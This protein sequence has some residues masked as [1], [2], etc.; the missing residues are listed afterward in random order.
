MRHRRRRAGFALMLVAVYTT[1][2][3]GAW[4]LAARQV[5]ALV[6]IKGALKA[7][8]TTAILDPDRLRTRAL[9]Y[10]LALLETGSPPV[11]PG[12]DEPYRCN[13]AITPARGRA[14]HLYPDLRAGRGRRGHLDH[15]RR[16]G[17]R[18]R[19]ARAGRIPRPGHPLRR[20]V[21][22]MLW[23]H[24]AL[25]LLFLFILG[26][27]IGSFAN[28]CI[29]RIPMGLNVLRPRSRCPGCGSAIAPFDNVPIVGR[30]RLRGRCRNCRAAI[31]P[32]YALVE[33]LVGLLPRRRLLGG[34]PWVRARSARRRSGH[35]RG[36]VVRRPGRFVR[37]GDRDVHGP[38][39]VESRIIPDARSTRLD[40]GSA[41][42]ASRRSRVTPGLYLNVGSGRA[43]G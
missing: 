28:V 19:P 26:S 18:L 1:M 38:R 7:R 9:A 29:Y 31:S 33:A 20:M 4:S 14:R 37:G 17:H 24:H 41:R 36:L 10:G 23:Y 43:T 15:R 11:D 3:L 13:V 12:S 40:P 35:A 25:I 6:R 2:T 39:R 21:T 16:P 27:C 5:S 32:R 22:H 34:H 42:T 30:L 8:E